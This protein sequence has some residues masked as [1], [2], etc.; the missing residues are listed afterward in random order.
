MSF[1]H[2]AVFSNQEIFSIDYSWKDCAFL[3]SRIQDKPS[4]REEDR[5]RQLH[6]VEQVIHF[7]LNE[8]DCR[9][10]QILQHFD[11]QFD[12]HACNGTCDN[13]AASY[14]VVEKDMSHEATSL[15]KFLLDAMALYSKVTRNRLIHAFRGGKLKQDEML[16]SSLSGYRLGK[17][18]S[19]ALVERVYDE[20]IGM[21]VILQKTQQTNGPYP[22]QYSYVRLS[23]VY[24]HDKI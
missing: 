1:T 18:T 23:A 15:V 2:S 13:C 11:E 16:L 6:E 10:V 5:Q 17:K 20:L 19:R 22:A 24:H 7:A 3:L 4:L 12:R 21:G 14:K 8:T 9:R